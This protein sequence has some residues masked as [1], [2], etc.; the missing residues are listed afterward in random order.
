MLPA[1]GRR[2]FL[3][4]AAAT[5]AAITA[6]CGG[7]G[8]D[9]DGA[10]AT[11]AT[12]SGDPVPLAEASA[13]SWADGP[14]FTLGVASGDPTPDAVILWT[15]LALDPTAGDGSGA[16]P[17]EDVEI[18]WDLA[19]DER[20]ERVLASA[21]VTARAADGHSVHVDATGLEAG[22]DH[23]YRF[24]LG[25]ETSTVGRTRTLPTGAPE[26]FSVAV[27]NCQ[28]YESGAYGA[29]RHLADEDVDLVAHLGDYIYEYAGGEGE[30]RHSLPNRVLETLGDYRLR[31]AS[32]RLDPDLAAAHAR[33]PFV[34]TWD[35]HEVANN[36]MGDTAPG[37]VDAE[38][39]RARKA[40][41]YRAW[42]E[43]LPV[44]LD[45][46]DGS[47]LAVY[48][49]FDAGDLARLVLLD[50]R[51]DAAEPPCRDAQSTGLDF[52]NCDEVEGED[53][54]RL[55]AD[56]EAW[57]ADQLATST[58]TWNLLG[59][60][61][62]LAGVDGGSD[63]AAYYLDTWDGFP[64]ARRRLIAQLAEVSNPVVLT[65]D[66]HAGMTLEVR[67]DP[68]DQSSAL[69]APEFMAPPISSVLFPQ[70]V[71]AR[72]PQLLEQLNH[73]GYLVVDVTPDE[74]TARFRV[75]DDVADPD[76]E[77]STASTW[78]VRAGDPE[79]TRA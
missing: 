43:N 19:A 26:R 69:V 35:D 71:S 47:D 77:I 27:V 23:W 74:L 16:M 5:A 31:Y 53:R 49:A 2:R 36:Y 45:P 38:V 20:F 57:L 6:G 58:A 61:V 11:T 12:G 79:P 32:Y 64:Q 34:A 14:V 28:M 46:P 1:V 4:G 65:G 78:T 66:Y 9:G 24:R 55:G 22:T 3:I 29:Y 42:W 54:T 10:S 48:R 18:A 39:V 40:A 72:T 60:P 13:P 56:Q 37:D 21:T 33:F 30:G 51:Q 67:A 73:H 7:D 70:D 25:D 62:V 68:F 75:L 44:R 8:S 41:A 17:D 50:E 63:T 52:G 76:T 15:R 59:N